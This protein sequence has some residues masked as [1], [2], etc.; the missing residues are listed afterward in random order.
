MRQTQSVSDRVRFM[1]SERMR[2]QTG[3]AE[4]GLEYASSNTNFVLVR[5]GSGA[6][7]K[8]GVPMREGV[9][10]GYPNRSRVSIGDSKE[11]G[12]LLASLSGA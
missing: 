8:A 11:K 2:I 6:L 5:T 9:S 1:T 4:A 12:R 10:L 7:E 3:F